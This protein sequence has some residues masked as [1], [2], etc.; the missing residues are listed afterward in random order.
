M[1]TF[2]SNLIFLGFNFF[3]L[4]NANI[5]LTGILSVLNKLIFIKHLE[6]CLTQMLFVKIIL[7]VFFGGND[8]KIY[9]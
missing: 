3:Y 4:I 1:C 7:K 9:I 6:Y 5:Y 2:V 8:G